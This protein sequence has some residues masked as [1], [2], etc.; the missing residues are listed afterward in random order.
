MYTYI[1][2]H[3]HIYIY[4]CTYLYTYS[5]CTGPDSDGESDGYEAIEALDEDALPADQGNPSACRL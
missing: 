2:K 3:T 1:Y 4:T 5:Y